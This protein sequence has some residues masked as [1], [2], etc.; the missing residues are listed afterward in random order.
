MA[1]G[2][3]ST[4]DNW[5]VETTARRQAAETVAWMVAY[6]AARWEALLVGE[7]AVRMAGD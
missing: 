7:M 3:A 2:K 6:W 1:A 4:S 5:M